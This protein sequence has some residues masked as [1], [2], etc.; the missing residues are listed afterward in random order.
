MKLCGTGV[1]TNRGNKTIVWQATALLA[2]SSSHPPP[3]TS[4]GTV[5]NKTKHAV[6]EATTRGLLKTSKTS[7]NAGTESFH[8]TQE[9]AGSLQP[10]HQENVSRDITEYYLPWPLLLRL[11]EKSTS[12]LLHLW[13]RF[14]SSSHLKN[15][16]W[17]SL[18]CNEP[19]SKETGH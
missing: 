9:A 14:P 16:S 10:C 6:K 19:S 17:P 2:T 11:A 13:K 8:S 15:R 18:V 3:V 5:W 12:L 7:L 1:N 4:T